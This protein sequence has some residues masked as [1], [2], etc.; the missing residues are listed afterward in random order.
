MITAALLTRWIT[1]HAHCRCC[2]LKN[3]KN[4]KNN[5]MNIKHN[6]GKITTEKE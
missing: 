4:A 5:R 3:I 2:D 6:I 1:L